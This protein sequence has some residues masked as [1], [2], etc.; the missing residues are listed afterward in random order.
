MNSPQVQSA[1]S[2]APSVDTSWR[3]IVVGGHTRSIGKTQLACDIISAFPG[4]DW[5]AGKI[6]Q[7]GHGVCARNGHECDC[8]PDEH[9]CAISWERDPGT[10]TDSSRFLAAGAQQS[11]WLR[12][13]QGFL[14]EGMPVLRS[15]LTGQRTRSPNAP[16]NLI[17]ESNT[18][19]Q[20]WRPAL[21][22]VVLDPRKPDFKSSARLHLDRA[23]ALVLRQPISEFLPQ[24]QAGPVWSG[25]PDPLL[26]SKPRFVQELGQPLPP[27]LVDTVAR[28]LA[29][30]V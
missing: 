17:L 27:Q 19:L 15:A 3:I 24:T 28:V 8:A 7:Y 13:K 12:T 14:A 11:F 25:V 16:R 18:L 6:T 5:I 1:S 22:L 10:G 30:P 2:T 21:Y 26:W 29:T 23:S 4:A 9:V 20:F